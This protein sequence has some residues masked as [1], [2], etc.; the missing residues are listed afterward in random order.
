MG[1]YKNHFHEVSKAMRSF[2]KD[3]HRA[4]SGL[5][6]ILA[7]VDAQEKEEADEIEKVRAFA[8]CAPGSCLSSQAWSRGARWP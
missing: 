6:R 1:V 4:E 5:E 2:D 3:L 7:H 8:C